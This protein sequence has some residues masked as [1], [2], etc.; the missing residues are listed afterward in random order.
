LIQV[1]FNL[2]SNAL[3]FIE[4]GVQPRL[5]LWTQQ[6][7]EFVRVCV[8]DNG[9]GIEPE[10]QEQVFR[11]FTRLSGE[12]YVG[13]GVGL[14]IVQAGVARMGGRT[15]VESTPRQGSRFWFELRRAVENP[16]E[17]S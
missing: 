2:T 10:Y 8:E 17:D 14:A 12:R 1:L 5:R 9:I 13:T 16:G 11:L 4:P 7:G 6:R 3:K 15:G